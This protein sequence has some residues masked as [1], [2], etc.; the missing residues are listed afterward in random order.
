M[1]AALISFHNVYNYGACLQAY[2]LQQA[3]AALGAEC[4]YIDYVNK[5]LADVYKMRVRI[6]KSLK[7]GDLKGV[8]KNVLGAPFAWSRKRKFNHFFDNRLKTTTKKYYSCKEASETEKL[9][10]KFIVGSDQVWNDGHNGCDPAYFLDF[11]ADNK[12][13][14]SYSSSFGMAEIPECD[15]ER[16]AKHLNNIDCLSTREKHG[17][18]LIKK[19]TGRHAHLVLDPVFLLDA[20]EWRKLIPKSRSNGDYTFYYMNARFNPND[21]GR[22]TGWKEEKKHIL[23]SSV[24]PKDFLKRDQ[25]ITFAM[26]P[27]VFLQEIDNAQLVVT[28]SFHC[29]AFAIILHKPFVAILSG[30]EGRDERLLNLL[31][32]TGL[33][34]RIF[35]RH[36][37]IEDVKK[38]IDYDLAEKR[39]LAYRE[40]SKSFL[41][42]ALYDGSAAVDALAEPA[43]AVSKNEKFIICPEDKCTGC[44]ACY[45]KC[46]TK[47]IQMKSDCDGFLSPVINEQLCVRC[48]TCKKVCQTN[49]KPDSV[50]EQHYYAFKNSDDIRRCSS[51]GGAFTALSQL[52]IADGGVVI[53]SQMHS[54]WHIEHTVADT[55]QKVKKQAATYYVQGKAFNRFKEAQE[56]LRQGRKVLFTGTPCQIAGLKKFLGR[57]YDNLITC[58]IICHGIPSPEMFRIYIDYLKQR[59]NLTS[60]KHR[61]KEIGWGGYSVS[62]VIDGKKY[63]NVG[64]LK[65]YSVM[66]S[67]GLINRNSCYHCRY[68]SFDRPGDITIGDY[69]GVEKHHKD[70]KDKLGVSLVIT[71]TQKGDE[72]FRLASKNIQLTPLEKQ[73]TLQPSLMKPMEVPM[74]RLACITQMRKSYE[75]AAKAYGEWSVKGKVKELIRTVLMK[76]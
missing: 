69:W 23:S 62:A 46:P 43:Y 19:L 36:M 64:W 50:S 15:H 24:S 70:I 67:H 3:V 45:E 53:A 59:G 39:L 30:D 68:S 27:E 7:A 21:F 55:M 76:H 34:D 61:D 38:P 25:K 20:E 13:K 26:H 29:L 8:V 75:S 22:V 65:A 11:V 31:Q 66:F 48:N 37:T 1:K 32:I 6:M 33:E 49:N 63:C 10:D 54:D 40:Y 57:D 47:A 5:E 73:E 52:V 56:L 72:F 2:A 28:T 14:I 60:L 35:S 17:V 44:G 16:F 58:D 74:Q 71:N 18:E 9:Y 51:S 12:K 42:A 4:E 41:Q